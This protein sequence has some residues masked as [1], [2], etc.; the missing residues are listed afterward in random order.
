M[1]ATPIPRTL[2]STI[3]MDMDVS[4][5]QCYPYSERKI[6]T[7]YLKDNNIDSEIEFINQYLASKQ[8]IYVVCP[9]INESSLDIS[10]VIEISNEFKKKFKDYNVGVIHGKMS[11][12]EKNEVIG[13]KTVEGT[14]RFELWE[15]NI[16]SLLGLTNAI[17]ECLDLGFQIIQDDIV[18][19]T[20]EIREAILNNPQL[21]LV[22]KKDAKIGNASFFING[23]A[24]EQDVKALFDKNGFI[25]S[26]IC[27]WDCPLFFPKNDNKYIF[28]VTPH[29][30]T[31]N[32]E[33][34]EIC[35]LIKNI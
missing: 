9:S 24:L 3:Y 26:C 12:N 27:D 32:D 10:N 30:Y 35:E 11:A 4:T 2:A 5:I 21:T 29:Y 16:A 28:R 19:K 34:R 7:Y 25:I 14:K 1:S 15:K 18:S 33:V 6:N 13:I 8:K 17:K 23:T 20:I 31:P 22:G